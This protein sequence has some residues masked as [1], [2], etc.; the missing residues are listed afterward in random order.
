[1]MHSRISL[2]TKHVKFAKRESVLS[3]GL[4]PV[5]EQ[6]LRE[7]PW[8]QRI[9]VT[10][11]ALSK[12]GGCVNIFVWSMDDKEP[13]RE[14]LDALKVY[15][16]AIRKVVAD[17]LCSKWTP[18]ISIRL[19]KK[20]AQARRAGGLM[21]KVFEQEHKTDYLTLDE[22]IKELKSKLEQ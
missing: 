9:F 22:T 17:I 7:S 20:I 16:P 5:V 6:T 13:G 1:M 2:K 18:E 11:V 4:I 10:R 21:N 19:D 8:L 14:A 12:E 3:K 15:R